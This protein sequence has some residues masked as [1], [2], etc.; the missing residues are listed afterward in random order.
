MTRTSETPGDDLN[1]SVYR[2]LFGAEVL[3]PLDCSDEILEAV[4]Q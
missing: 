2:T 3:W 1:K 4:I